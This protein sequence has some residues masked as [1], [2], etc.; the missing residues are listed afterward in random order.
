MSEQGPALTSEK[1]RPHKKRH[2]AKQPQSRACSLTAPPPFPLL[3]TPFLPRSPQIPQS[4][5]LFFFLKKFFA[6]INR[7]E[8]E[9][10]LLAHLLLL[11]VWS[12]AVLGNFLGWRIPVLFPSLPRDIPGAHTLQEKGEDRCD[13]RRRRRRPRKKENLVTCRMGKKR[14]TWSIRAT[15]SFFSEDMFLKHTK[16]PKKCK[17]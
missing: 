5:F 12:V 16:S 3:S 14:L 6:C 1:V 4:S 13:R 7:I 10:L 11:F 9:L 8:V 2:V 15:R 17:N